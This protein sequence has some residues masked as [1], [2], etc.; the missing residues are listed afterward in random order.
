MI[1]QAELAVILWDN[2]SQQTEG[3]C[4]CAERDESPVLLN[5]SSSQWAEQDCACVGSPSPDMAFDLS[6]SQEETWQIV[7][8]L[9]R[10]AL[11]DSYELIFNPAGPTGI[12]V[13]NKT[14]CIALD[15]YSHPHGLIDDTAR[16]LATLQ[17][18]APIRVP[19]LE[20]PKIQSTLTVWLHVTDACNLRCAYCYLD[21]TGEA[22][23]E[24][25]GHAAIDAVIR[26]AHVNGFRA[27]KL[28]YAG[29]EPTLNFSLVQ[30]LHH[31]TQRQA[32]RAGL[33]L[34]EVMLSNGVALTPTMIDWLRAENVRLMI[35]LDGIGQA[36]DSQRAFI[37]GHGSFALVA[38]G[39]D[40]ALARG[41]TPHLSITVTARNADQ[42]A[43]AVAFAIERDLPFN[44]N[45][46]REKDCV[47]P[48]ANLAVDHARLIAGMKAAFAVIEANL[49]QRRLID[50]LVDRS[51]FDA[52]HEHPCGVGRDYL[53]I[54][55]RGQ[56]ARCQMDIKQPVTDVLAD[57]PLAAVRNHSQGFQNVSVGGKTGCA[58]CIWRFWCAGGCPLHTFRATGHSDVKSPYCNVYQ[59]LYPDA[60]RLEGLRLMRW[61]TPAD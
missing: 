46:F 42:L 3:D 41:L 57:D 60:L 15:T 9:Y 48:A 58:K 8:S 23:A 59:A 45:F 33:A 56:V 27:I 1:N 20:I 34:R 49:P 5:A 39:L 52:P 13:L 14:A 19:K 37:K 61:K 17:L 38:R 10:A 25:T 44:L 26:S 55:Q 11:P 31:Y 47:A 51:A 18:I 53:V 16:Q 28:K 35:S 6:T 21:K 54:D 2:T 4:A 43:D 29:G 12:M 30:A 50:G 40:R 22:M 36:H 7:P 24:D 32:A